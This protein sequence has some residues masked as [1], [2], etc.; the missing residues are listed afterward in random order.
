M[1]T[2]LFAVRPCGMEARGIP[3]HRTK[4]KPRKAGLAWV[5]VL[6][7]A[8]P[9]IQPWLGRY[10]GRERR[11]VLHPYPRRSL[12]VRNV[13]RVQGGNDAIPTPG[14]KSDHSIVAKKPAKAG[15][16]KGVMG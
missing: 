10:W 8:T 9:H 7:D 13:G 14:E 4:V 16:A 12:R 5:S 1:T 11:E 3:Q 15:R 2:E 6:D